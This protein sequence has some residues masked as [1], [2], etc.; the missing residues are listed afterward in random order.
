MAVACVSAP[1]A[2]HPEQSTGGDEFQ[3]MRDRMV[4]EQIASAAADNRR[5]VRDA[6]V[7]QAMRTV[8][9]ERFVAPNLRHE[10][11]GDYPLPI[12]FDQTISQ[13]YIV[14]FMTEA[15]RVG[16][17][18]VVLEVGTGSGYQAAV[19]A[20]IV[21]K[22]YTI[23]IVQPL[24]DRAARRLEELGYHNVHVRAGDGYAGWPE[25]APFDAIIVTA[26]PERVPPALIEQLKPGGRMVIPVG[27]VDR[28][29]MLQVLT[30]RPDG[31]VVRENVMAV[32]FVPMVGN[33]TAGAPAARETPIP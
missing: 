16:P 32:R 14:A 17:E 10:A 9:R 5:P 31:S 2:D 1:G 15:A 28:T 3:A 21:H 20:E 6:A 19:L 24:A 13:P 23:E 22:V 26:A 25:H 33:P 12:G 30:K 27:P 11:F 4:D 18:S 29:Q 7:L 8:P